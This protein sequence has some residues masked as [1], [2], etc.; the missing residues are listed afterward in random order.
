MTGRW[1]R[2]VGVVLLVVAAV[3]A[4]ASHDASVGPLVRTVTVGRDPLAVAIAV[5]PGRIFVTNS[6]SNTVSVLD[7]RSATVLRTIP[8]GRT[9]TG[10]VPLT[11]HP[12]T[13]TA[14]DAHNVYI[15]GV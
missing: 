15:R 3:Q 7:A 10:I 14:S 8:V 9:L 4:I 13:A 6:G 12:L 11:D 2:V 5:H 1:G